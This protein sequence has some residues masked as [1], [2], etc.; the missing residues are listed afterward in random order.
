[1][2]IHS[3]KTIQPH[4]TEV[5]KRSKKFEVRKNDRNFKPRDLLILKE[6]KPMEQA[7]TGQEINCEVTSML[8]GGQYG[9]AKEYCIMSI[10]IISKNF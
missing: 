5:A 10:K 9:I 1:M 4:F 6:W 8:K 7:Y 3:L 2:A